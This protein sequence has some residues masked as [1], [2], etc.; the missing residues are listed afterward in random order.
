MKTQSLLEAARALLCNES[1]DEI[2]VAMK[3]LRDY[4]LVIDA[5]SREGETGFLRHR[6]GKT[7]ELDRKQFSD[8]LDLFDREGLEKNIVREDLEKDPGEYDAEGSMAKNALRTIIRN[9]KGLHDMLEDDENLPEHVQAA[10]VRAEEAIVGARD[11]LESE[12]EID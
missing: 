3:N 4:T 1:I 7:I 2:D 5:N 11:Y 9:A 8:F 12:K 6:S 10:I